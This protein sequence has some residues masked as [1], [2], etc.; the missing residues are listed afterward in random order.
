MKNIG[1][2]LNSKNVYFIPFGQDDYV[3]KPNS[4]IAHTDMLIPTIEAAL[5]GKQIQP[6]IKSPY[7]LTIIG[8]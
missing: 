5:E 1:L 7:W 4:L 3:K 6:I 2:L 8:Q